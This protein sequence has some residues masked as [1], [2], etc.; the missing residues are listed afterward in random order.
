MRRAI[1][2]RAVNRRTRPK[3]PRAC[4]AAIFACL[5]MIA[6]FQ[7][8]FARAQMGPVTVHLPIVARGSSAAPP[9]IDED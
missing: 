3:W 1:V 8:P 7:E 4:L 5:V 2:G 9:D 6:V